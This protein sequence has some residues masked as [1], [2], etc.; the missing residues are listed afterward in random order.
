MIDKLEISSWKE[1]KRSDVLEICWRYLIGITLYKESYD[2]LGK[3]GLKKKFLHFLRE[4]DDFEV[5]YIMKTCRAYIKYAH[6]NI[7]LYR[8][9]RKGQHPY[10]KDRSFLR[11]LR[12]KIDPTSIKIYPYPNSSSVLANMNSTIYN[13]VGKMFYCFSPD[14]SILQEDFVS[15]IKWK[16]VEVYRQYIFSLGTKNFNKKVFFSVLNRAITSRF[17]DM[18]NTATND[19]RKVNLHSVSLEDFIDGANRDMKVNTFGTKSNNILLYAQN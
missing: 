17:I 16:L 5:T 18:K 3:Y 2:L 13:R 1:K 4:L 12:K 7:D 14:R 8:R 11:K 9:F 6:V 10:L 15:E 19:H